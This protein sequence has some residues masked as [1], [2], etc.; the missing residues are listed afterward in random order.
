MHINIKK[1]NINKLNIYIYIHNGETARRQMCVC[2][3]MYACAKPTNDKQIHWLRHGIDIYI[4][5]AGK[6]EDTPD[7]LAKG[8]ACLHPESAG[9]YP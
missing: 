2:V 4:S 6:S 1:I 7:L 3:C 5:R 9:S 8:P